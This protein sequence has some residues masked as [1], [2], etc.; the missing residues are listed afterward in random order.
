MDGPDVHD[1]YI[2]FIPGRPPFSKP[3]QRAPMCDQELI[4]VWASRHNISW[5]KRSR[6]LHRALTK[7][8]VRSFPF[9]LVFCGRV[10]KIP[11]H[12]RGRTSAEQSVCER[13]EDS[14]NHPPSPTITHELPCAIVVRGAQTAREASRSNGARESER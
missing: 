8:L 11:P 2:V 14:H 4:T 13:L 9:L 10:V 5:S 12:L 7:L 6:A 3:P 1:V